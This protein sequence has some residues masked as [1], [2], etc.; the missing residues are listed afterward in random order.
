MTEILNYISAWVTLLA[1]VLGLCVFLFDRASKKNLFLAA[2]LRAANK[3]KETSYALENKKVI[4][5]LGTVS[6]WLKKHFSPP[7]TVEVW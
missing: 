3:K 2:R 4:F 1:A 5:A 6:G 7:S